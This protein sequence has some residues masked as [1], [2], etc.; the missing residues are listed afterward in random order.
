[1]EVFEKEAHLTAERGNE[2]LVKLLNSGVLGIRFK[3][4]NLI[5]LSGP[6]I[7][8]IRRTWSKYQHRYTLNIA[9]KAE[10]NYIP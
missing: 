5:T 7:P 3:E 10:I 4:K 9:E 8:A 6:L 1:M 2:I